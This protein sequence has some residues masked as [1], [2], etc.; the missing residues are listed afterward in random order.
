MGAGRIP[1]VTFVEELRKLFQA[2]SLELLVGAGASIASGLPSWN[3]LNRRLLSA[4]LAREHSDLEFQ[5]RDLDVAARI[6]VDSFGREAVVDVVRDKIPPE[7]YLELLREALYREGPK[8]VSSIHLELAAMLVAAR[9]TAKK[10]HGLYTF[11]FDDLL[12]RSMERL[13]G[14][15][16]EVIVEGERPSEPHVVHLHGYLS[17]P[18][19]RSGATGT[20]VLS[21]KDYHEARGDWASRKLEDLFLDGKRAILMV[22]LSL[23]DPRLRWLLLE[24]VKLAQQGRPVAKVFALLSSSPPAPDAALMERLARNFVRRHQEDFWASWKMDVLNLESHDM[25]PFYLRQVRL[26]ADGGDWAA[27][28]ESF[29]RGASNVFRDLYREDVQR[30]AVAVLQEM[31]S[32]VRRRFAVPRDEELHMGGFV[33]APGAVIRMGFSCRGGDGRADILDEAYAR[34]RSLSVASLEKAQGASGRAFLLGANI[35]ASRRSPQVHRNF[36]AEMKESWTRDQSFSS[37]VCVPIYDSRDWVPIGVSY[38]TSNRQ[39]PFWASL[40][41]QDYDDLVTLLRNTF[42]EV[43][44]YTPI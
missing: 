20:V 2:G 10:L 35:E 9:S 30:G 31:H 17:P 7:G 39:Q 24:R 23:A 5:T 6:F 13:L 27:K 44:E 41:P 19:G 29:L 32:L 18:E 1:A 36:T 43:L 26:G 4:F 12:E 14:H 8:D 40:D 22:G 34:D 42:T 28:G 37:L 3:E 21:E 16:P 11:N 15:R 25:V 33:P 38:L